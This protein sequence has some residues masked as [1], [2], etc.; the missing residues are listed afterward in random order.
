MK[1]SVYVPAQYYLSRTITSIRKITVAFMLLYSSIEV[2]ESCLIR[3]AP[4]PL[5]RLPLATHQ[6]LSRLSYNEVR[7][8][9]QSCHHKDSEF[10]PSLIGRCTSAL[11][12][13]LD[14]VST[15]S[16]TF[17]SAPSLSSSKPA[18]SK[19]DSVDGDS[20]FGRSDDIGHQKLI[21]SNWSIGSRRCSTVSI[22]TIIGLFVPRLW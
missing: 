14:A 3:S 18:S 20:P 4:T 12:V 15:M 19:T 9:T 8:L 22:G 10:P 21:G 1:H 5:S 16:V 17:A 2:S 6:P 11:S 7:P 13:A